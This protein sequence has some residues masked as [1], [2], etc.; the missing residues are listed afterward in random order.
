[1]ELEWHDQVSLKDTN[2]L[3][4]KVDMKKQVFCLT[5]G[6]LFA[7]HDINTTTAAFCN[8][9]DENRY[10]WHHIITLYEKENKTEVESTGFLKYPYP[11]GFNIFKSILLNILLS[12]QILQVCNFKIQTIK[13]SIKLQ[14]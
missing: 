14:Q 9:S 11:I 5:H 4:Q 12:M 6:E 10:L 8:K 7:G 13:F 1:M 2:K 3:K